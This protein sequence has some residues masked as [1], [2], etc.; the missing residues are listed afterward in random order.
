MHTNDKKGGDL[1]FGCDYWYSYPY[2]GRNKKGRNTCGTCIDDQEHN[3]PNVPDFGCDT[4]APFCGVTGCNETSWYKCYQCINN[5]ED[6][7][8][9]TGCSGWQ[10]F[11]AAD[12]GT[13]RL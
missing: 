4:S 5:K 1:D 7:S 13:T 9:D 10:P 2:C 3:D 8:Q 6:N 12:L 11:C